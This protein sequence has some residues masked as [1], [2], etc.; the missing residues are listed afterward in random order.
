MIR[1]PRRGRGSG[2]PLP[3][4]SFTGLPGSAPACPVRCGGCLPG[5]WWTL[6]GGRL[7]LWSR[8]CRARAKPRSSGAGGARSHAVGRPADRRATP[9][10]AGRGCA[11]G[12]NAPL[13]VSLD[14][15]RGQAPPLDPADGGVSRRSGR[16]VA[17]SC[18]PPRVW[19]W[20]ACCRCPSAC[21]PAVPI[22]HGWRWRLGAHRERGSESGGLGDCRHA[23]HR[24]ERAAAA[25]ATSGAAKV[26]R[27]PT[28]H[29]KNRR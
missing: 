24:S 22:P 1:E 6:E 20:A 15:Q 10:G 3:R 17:S 5:T 23:Q 9:Q 18:D 8:L 29:Q 21:D 14:G 28:L 4:R 11:V 25:L 13:P 16:P 19:G 12:L 2:F 27:L 7:G 26:Q